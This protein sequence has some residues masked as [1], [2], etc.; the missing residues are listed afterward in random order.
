MREVNCL[1]AVSYEYGKLIENDESVE[2][3][4]KRRKLNVSNLVQATEK[5]A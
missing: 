2:S 4:T 3:Q 5:V 1:C